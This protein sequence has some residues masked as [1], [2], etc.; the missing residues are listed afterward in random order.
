MLL[1]CAIF[2][3]HL[4]EQFPTAHVLS[5]VELVVH[6]GQGLKPVE[7]ILILVKDLSQKGGPSSHVC[8]QKYCCSVVVLSTVPLP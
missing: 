3:E 2:I 1:D 6:P 4:T 5:E 8:H 7:H